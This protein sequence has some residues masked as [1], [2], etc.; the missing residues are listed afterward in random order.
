[1]NSKDYSILTK[2]LLFIAICDFFDN[3]SYIKSLVTRRTFM[4]IRIKVIY[5]ND[6]SSIPKNN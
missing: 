5:A 6:K 2:D 3:T 1:M 4:L